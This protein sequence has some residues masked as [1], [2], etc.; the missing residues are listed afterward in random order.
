[1]P[2]RNS[3][4]QFISDDMSISLPG[5]TGL[6]KILLIAVLIFPWY[7]ILSNRNFSTTLFGYVIGKNFTGCPQCDACE[8]PKCPNE[9]FDQK[10]FEK[11]IKESFVCQCKT[12][13]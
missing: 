9:K 8:C 12:P 4:G 5:F 3:K 7:V 11:M 1:M 2:S 10:A 13:G 6:Y